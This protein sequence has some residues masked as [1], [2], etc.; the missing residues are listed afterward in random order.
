[1]LCLAPVRLSVRSRA[2]HALHARSDA[3]PQ[4]PDLND[5]IEPGAALR[6]DARQ[7]LTRRLSDRELS[8]AAPLIHFSVGA[9]VG[10]MYGAF[11]STISHDRS[12][13]AVATSFDRAG[14]GQASL[15]WCVCFI[16]CRWFCFASA[17]LLGTPRSVRAGRELRGSAWPA[18]LR[19][20]TVQCANA[21]RMMPA[22]ARR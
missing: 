14:A 21:S 9:A 4:C 7:R 3:R 5:Q 22:R 12:A 6:V 8:I 20:E 11:R 17:C 2:G 19:A 18:V 1:M 15:I 10:A 16:A 13:T